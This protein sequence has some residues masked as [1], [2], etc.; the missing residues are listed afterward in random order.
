MIKFYKMHGLGND[1]VYFDCISETLPVEKI[2]SLVPEISDRHLGIGSDGVVLLLPSDKASVRMRM[3]NNHDGKE[4]EMCGN[5]V[6]CVCALANELGLSGSI[7]S[8]ETIPGIISA[9]VENY[10]VK[11]QMFYPPKIENDKGIT[12]SVGK[13]FKYCSVDV[14]N[15]HAVIEASDIDNFE[16]EKYGK[17]IE[18]QIE[19]FPNKTNV[20]F[21]EELSPGIVKMRVW[22]RGSGET[23][24]CGT[25]ACATAGAYRLNHPECDEVIVKMLGGDLKLR[26]EDNNFYMTG[27]TKFVFVG[28][29]D[30]DNL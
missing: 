19:L 29:I 10:N 22:E 1:Y 6:R 23:Q 14:G 26:W 4:A 24:A 25:G 5:A 21:Y 17:P 16:V 7:M 18:T 12:T 27:P 9:E 30:L 13:E 3:F 8:V 15:P 2:I 28:G 20:E 11:V